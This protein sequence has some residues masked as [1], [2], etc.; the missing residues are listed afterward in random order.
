MTTPLISIIMA[1][2]NA[3]KYI[4][5]AIKSVL[6]QEYQNWELIII[7]DGSRDSTEKVVLS[8][9]DERIHYQ[10]QENKGVSAARNAGLQ[11]MKGEFFYFFD[12]DD[13]LSPKSLSS[14]ISIFLTS[15]EITFVDGRVNK[16]TADLQK[17]IGTHIPSFRGNPF[18]QLVSLNGNC[19]FGITWMIRKEENKV[20]HFDETMKHAEDLLF[21]ISIAQTGIYDFTDEV[22]LDYRSNPTSAMSDIT[23]LGKGYKSLLDNAKKLNLSNEQLSIMRSKISSIMFKSHLKNGSPL[24]AFRALFEY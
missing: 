3:E 17:Q 13:V 2:Y 18:D 1:A 15:P 7:N 16:M 19:F 10:K 5:E 8:F 22:I 11:I 12:A 23:G 4:A 6:L 9:N 21:F 14:R 24:R 20:Y